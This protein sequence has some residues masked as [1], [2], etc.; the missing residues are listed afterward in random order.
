MCYQPSGY[1]CLAPM[2]GCPLPSTLDAGG[3]PSPAQLTHH[4]CAFPRSLLQQS[5]PRLR[6]PVP[7]STRVQGQSGVTH[8]RRLQA[9]ANPR[10]LGALPGTATTE[11]SPGAVGNNGFL[12]CQRQVLC[13]PLGTRDILWG[14]SSHEPPSSVPTHLSIHPSIPRRKKQPG[15]PPFPSGGTFTPSPHILPRQGTENAGWPPTPATQR[16]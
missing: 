3:E 13:Q 8:R 14:F 2:H 4:H 12:T 7:W 5:L 11:P 1:P 6:G 15:P 10:L 9:P 16:E